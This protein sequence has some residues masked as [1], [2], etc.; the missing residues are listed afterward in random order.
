[1]NN[2]MRDLLEMLQKW[3]NKSLVIDDGDFYEVIWGNAHVLA[4]ARYEPAKDLFIQG[5]Y[6][7]DWVWRSNCVSLLG[8]H[9]P[10]DRDV[11]AKIRGLLVVD[12]NDDVRISAASVLGRR[13]SFPDYAL[14]KALETDKNLQV[15]EAAYDSILELA[16]VP[17]RVIQK[18]LNKIRAGTAIP[19]L[20]D[21]KRVLKAE[22][23]NYLDSDFEMQDLDV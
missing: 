7:E 22:N 16:G 3:K 13:S 12:P 11:V 5:L 15:K 9:Y 2:E 20:A 18:E 1:M 23:I 10:L 17:F 6:D 4:E 21:V 8:F 19:S 14:N